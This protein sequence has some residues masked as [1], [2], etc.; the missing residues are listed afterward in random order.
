MVHSTVPIFLGYLE[1]AEAVIGDK[2][3]G[4]LFCLYL[5]QL[6]HHKI[7]LTFLDSHLQFWEN[8]TSDL[9]LTQ[10]VVTIK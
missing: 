7:L 5:L 2:S 9:F 10:R 1:E 6:C 4:L 8:S 3:P